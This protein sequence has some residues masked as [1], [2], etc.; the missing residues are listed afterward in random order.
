MEENWILYQIT[1]LVNG[2]I[3]IGVHKIT[4]TPRC[5]RYLGSGDNILKAIKKYGRKNFVRE[6]L[7]EFSCFEEAYKAEANAVDEDFIKRPDT[8]NIKLGGTGVKGVI[9]TEEG[10]KRIS[11]AN[12]GKILSDEHKE[13]LRIA[14][15][16]R[17][18]SEE[19]RAKLSLAGKN[20]S[21]TQETKEKL[22]VAMKARILS[23]EHKLNI[24]KAHKG[25]I[26]TDDT[27]LKISKSKT[28]V[29]NSRSSAVVINGEY[30]AS[31]N[32]AAK[33][34]GEYQATL[35]NRVKNPNPKFSEWR[36]ATEEEKSLHNRS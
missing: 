12:K 29:N 7:A 34:K 13:K 36:F 14:N 8:Y 9:I 32:I 16:G 27:K 24:G 25:R 22:R 19:T 20:K 10:R 15:I 11:A 21:L 4:N 23:E 33:A 6:T 1:N 35:L 5:K 26:V 17:I 31:A 28:G 30:Y 3:Y 2:K 18:R